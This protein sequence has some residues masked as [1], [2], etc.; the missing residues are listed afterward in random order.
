MVMMEV[1]D[2]LPHDRVWREGAGA[3]WHQTL[4][5]LENRKSDAAGHAVAALA[6]PPGP[7]QEVLAPLDDALIMRCLHTW[8]SGGGGGGRGGGGGTAAGGLRASLLDLL[9][10]VVGGGTGGE[11]AFLPTGALRLFDALHAAR[12]AHRL[13]AADFDQLP[14]TV[15]DGWNAPL[16]ASTKG[17][18]T[19]D[20]ATYL[21]QPG[22][23]DIFFPSSF[24][25][26]RRLHSVAGDE[27]GRRARSGRCSGAR[28]D[29]TPRRGLRC[30]KTRQFVER[31]APDGGAAAA[32]RDGYNPLL[33]DYSN[34]TVL[35]S[36]SG[37]SGV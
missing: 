35:V 1:L 9:R 23:A 26:L 5:G 15:V 34:T 22:A 20:H 3:A 16:V 25:L 18:G 36:E 21:V 10:R 30:M 6:A 19:V 37:P 28:D 7:F 8:E 33:L 13:I 11:A 17:G 31:Y 32:T 12:P 24:E 27:A 2:N 14:E 29:V 4:V